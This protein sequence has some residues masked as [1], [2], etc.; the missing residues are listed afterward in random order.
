MPSSVSGSSPVM[1][2]KYQRT[3]TAPAVMASSSRAQSRRR[4]AQALPSGATVAMRMMIGSAAR[5]DAGSSA[6]DASSS[7]SDDERARLMAPA[8]AAGASCKVSR[9]VSPLADARAH[10]IEHAPARRRAARR[11]ARRRPRAAPASAS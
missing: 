10:R 8:G 11:R 1:P 2:E 9:A 6:S 4:L 3:R 7:S 5:A